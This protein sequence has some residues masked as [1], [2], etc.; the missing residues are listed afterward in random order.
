MYKNILAI[1]IVVFILAVG[2][3]EQVFIKDSFDT[4]INYCEEI[5]QLL[6]DKNYQTAYEKTLQFQQLWLKKRDWLEFLC[7]NNDVKDVA[8]E[9]GELKGSQTGLMYDDAI[10]RCDVISALC[11]S[12]KNL[13]SF[14]WKNVF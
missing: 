11:E 14:K 12:S 13:L 7:P 4:A 9:I 1:A 8:K 6:L 3:A 2:I 10:T 5:Q